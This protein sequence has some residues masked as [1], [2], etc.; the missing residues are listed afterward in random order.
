MKL[1]Q[2][3]KELKGI[4]EENALLFIFCIPAFIMTIPIELLNRKTDEG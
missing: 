1:K 2:I 4:W 3:L